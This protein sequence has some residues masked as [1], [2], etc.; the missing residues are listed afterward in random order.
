MIL[1]LKS[2]LQRRKAKMFLMFL[3]CSGLIWFLNNLS[4]PYI[5]STVFQLEYVN[6]PDS[7]LLLKTSKS[8]VNVKLQATGFQ[9]LGFN[10]QSKT[11]RID[12][13][14]ALEQGSRFISQNTYRR[15]IEKQLSSMVLLEI[16]RDTLFL[17]FAK[18]ISKKVDVRPR[19]AIDLAQNYFLDGPLEI[20]PNRITIKGPKASLDSI[21]HLKT[22]EMRFQAGSSN[23]SHQVQLYKSPELKHTDYS[24]N[25]VVI[26][27]KVARFSEKMV[28]VP[29][30]VINLPEGMQIRT[31]PE[32][33]SI[34]CRAK[35]DDLKNL[36]ASDF[37]VVADY[38]EIK[39]GGAKILSL[40]LRNEPE[41]LHST[42][43]GTVQVEYILKRP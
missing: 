6:L 26:R 15:Q 36:D 42:R 12:V 37:Q 17:D 31:F 33:V 25:K 43:L 35:I 21:D 18:V 20:E 1:K 30:E 22:V 39:I 23:F 10:L 7:L 29:V 11:V 34:L 24:S 40:Q 13:G 5:D 28:E 4:E 8:E 38:G 41:N 16:D 19:V 9:F 14:S 27:G 2:L 32:K 3:A